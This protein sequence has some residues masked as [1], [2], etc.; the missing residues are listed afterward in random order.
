MIEPDPML[1]RPPMRHRRL[2]IVL[3]AVLGLVV[4]GPTLFTVWLVWA[5]HGVVLRIDGGVLHVTTG[6]APVARH[7]RFDLDAVAGV[8][9][10][11]LDPGRRV[12]G[13]ALPGYCV[14][15][16]RYNRL[17]SVWQATDCSH[18]VVILHRSDDRPIVLT[19]PDRTRFLQALADGYGY[20]ERQPPPTTGP[21]WVA[22]KLFVLTTPLIGVIIPLVF[23]VGP[24]R[25][26]YRVESGSLVVTT[27]IGS[28]RF[29]T[30]GCTARPHR[31]RDGLRLWGVGAPGLHSGL[32]RLDGKNTKVYA[33]STEAGVLIDGP[34]VRVF[35]NPEN[36]NAFLEAIHTVG[37]AT[38]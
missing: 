6:P 7:H 14:G 11:T 3:G 34:G 21:G 16:Y 12:A 2:H 13:T 38:G 29:T 18:E 17:G 8:E 36:E 28:R 4:L 22:L 23:V 30:A 25:L 15:R 5:P 27:L 19:P 35:V 26:S 33:T 10:A 20:H 9:E 37:G 31:P 32:Y 24:R 1:F